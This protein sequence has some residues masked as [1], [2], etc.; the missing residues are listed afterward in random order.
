MENEELR[1]EKHVAQPNTARFREP[2]PPVSSQPWGV[3]RP[4]GPT[5]AWGRHGWEEGWFQESRDGVVVGPIQGLWMFWAPDGT[6]HGSHPVLVTAGLL[7]LWQPLLVAGSC[8]WL[9]VVV[10]VVATAGVVVVVVTAGVGV[11]VAVV[12]ARSPVTRRSLQ[13]QLWAARSI[14]R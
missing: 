6:L 4:S 1:L 14:D 11:S 7:L 9:F 8:F 5:D 3:S 12:V 2:N 10:V 13:P